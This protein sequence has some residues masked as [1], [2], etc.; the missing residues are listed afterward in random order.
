MTSK[1][2]IRTLEPEDA[3]TLAMMLQSQPTTYLQY[4]IPFRFEEATVQ[5]ILQQANRDVYMGIFWQHELAGFFMLRGWDAGYDVPAYG[6]V[7]AHAF[8]GH[9][10]G[11]LSLELSK[12]ICRLRQVRRIM[13]KVH[14]D[15]LA[16][17][18][19][20]EMAGFMPTGVD[21]Q[22]HNLIYRYDL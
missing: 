13:L 7:I 9:G 20:Y 3:P 2:V 18:Y 21:P 5:G 6:V 16:A 12:T 4:F 14:P 10:L 1:F 8:R 22:N 19:I 15:N 11:R 17:K